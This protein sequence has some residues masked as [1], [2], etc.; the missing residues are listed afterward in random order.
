MKLFQNKKF[1]I[2]LCVVGLL[3]RPIIIAIL[4]SLPILPKLT[5]NNDWI[6][7]WGGYLGSILGGMITLFVLK[8]TIDDNNKLRK[9]DEKISYYNHLTSYTLLSVQ[10][11]VI[12][13]CWQIDI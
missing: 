3:L 11:Q 2:L 1:V 4:V 13:V 6:G 8:I 5:N 12:Y 10:Q 9:R 7:F